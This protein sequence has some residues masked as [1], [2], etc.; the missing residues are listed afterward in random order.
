MRALISKEKCTMCY[1]YLTECKE[2]VS[3]QLINVKQ[4]GGLQY[5][6]FDVVSVLQIANITLENALTSLPLPHVF[7][8]ALEMTK[9]IVAEILSSNDEYFQEIAAHSQQHKMSIIKKIVFNE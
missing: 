2:R 8:F 1:T 7:S 5:P 4:L 3:C 6:T 9:D